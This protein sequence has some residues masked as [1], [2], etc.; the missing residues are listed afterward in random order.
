MKPKIAFA[1]VEASKTGFSV[2]AQDDALP[3]NGYGKTIEEAKAD[4]LEAYKEM[5]E[6]YKEKDLPLPD[7]YNNGNL[8]FEYKYD[9]ASIFQHFGVL[10]ATQFAH[11][12]GMNPSLLRQY[13]TGH[14]L[15]SDKQKKKIE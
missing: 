6:Y 4:F 12:I 3:M 9:I 11:K 8:K 10:D 15:A 1:V 2:Y 7:V 5:L 14:A 13:K